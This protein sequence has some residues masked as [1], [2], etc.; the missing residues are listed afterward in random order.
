MMANT[1]TDPHCIA[2][3]RLHAYYDGELPLAERRQVEEHLLSCHACRREL[4]ALRELSTT[5][6]AVPL[7]IGSLPS[8][9]DFWR[10]LA[11]RLSQRDSSRPLAV[12]WPSL[13]PLSVVLTGSLVNAASVCLALLAGALQWNIIPPAWLESMGRVGRHL[14]GPTVWSAGQKVVTELGGRLPAS[15]TAGSTWSLVLQSASFGVASVLGC[16]YLV[17]IALSSA[18]LDRIEQP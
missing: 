16:L 4:E 15:L 6:R 14:V 2:S 7:P 12:P 5:L 8:D 1:R 10:R 9:S 17:W 13:A 18:N 3:R 11:P